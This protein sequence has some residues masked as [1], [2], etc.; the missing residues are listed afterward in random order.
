[1]AI[2]GRAEGQIICAC[3]I[4]QFNRQGYQILGPYPCDK[5]F[6]RYC[7]GDTADSKTGSLAATLVQ[8]LSGEPAD[9][10]KSM[11]EER[12]ESA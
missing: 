5:S 2:F 6:F 11:L 7:K 10:Q 1:M 8:A 3:P 4:T 12:V 9:V